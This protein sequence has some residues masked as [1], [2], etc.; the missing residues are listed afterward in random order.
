MKVVICGS[1]GDFDG[2]LK[3]LNHARQTYGLKNV[4]PDDEHLQKAMPSIVAHHV[5]NKENE[6]TIDDRSKLMLA[7]FDKIDKADL[8]IIINE[9]YDSEYYGVGTTI[10]LGYALAKSKKICLTKMPTNPNILSLLK[11]HS[12]NSELNIWRQQ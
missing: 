9:K 8:V 1:F 7:Y 5:T 4:F 12:H 3:V 11:M 6:E 2:F 10:E